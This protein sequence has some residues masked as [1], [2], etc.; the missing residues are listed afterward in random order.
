MGFVYT[1]YAYKKNYSHAT[2]K[3]MTFEYLFR[4]VI[5]L[6]KDIYEQRINQIVYWK[7]QTRENMLNALLLNN[8]DVSAFKFTHLYIHD[9]NNIDLLLLCMKNTNEYYLEHALRESIFGGH[10][11]NSHAFIEDIL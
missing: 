2:K 8:C 3:K 6:N 11:I 7:I 5:R 10:L 9:A 1:V 4:T